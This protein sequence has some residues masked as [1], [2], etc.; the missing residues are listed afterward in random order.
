[1]R[2]KENVEFHFWASGRAEGATRAA[3]Q[4]QARLCMVL[5]AL[6]G[7]VIVHGLGSS[8]GAQEHIKVADVAR[9]QA[10]FETRGRETVIQA[11]HNAIINYHQFNVPAQAAVRFVQPTARSRVLNRIR[12]NAPSHIDGALSANGIV[13]LVNPAG[14][15]F[16]P[17]SVVNVGELFA[18]AGNITDADFRV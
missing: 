18:A 11:S 15:Y 7:A 17:N 16:G 6:V 2:R 5:C 10:Q 8:A 14:I 4:P 1:M 9:G 3:N 13:Y 12:S